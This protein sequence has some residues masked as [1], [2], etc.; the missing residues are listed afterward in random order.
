MIFGY[1][2]IIENMTDNRLKFERF[3]YALEQGQFSS[4]ITTHWHKPEQEASLV[5]IPA[6]LDAQLRLYLEANGFNGLYSHQAASFEAVRN[7]R[8]IIVSTG[9]SSGKTWCYNLPVLHTLFQVQQTRALYLFPTKALTEDQ[10]KK[11]ETI[12]AFLEENVSSEAG[13]QIKAGIYDGDTPAAKRKSIRNN[14]NIILTNPDMLHIGILPHHTVWSEFLAN[15]RYIVLDEVHT[16]R[17]VFGSHVANVLRRLKRVLAFYGAEPT[18]ILSS[19]TIQNPLELSEALVEEHFAA[20]TQDGSYQPER[21]YFFLNPPIVN[22]ELGLRRG[23]ID[24]SVEVEKEALDANIQSLVFARSRKTVE[25]TL[26]NLNERYLPIERPHM[27]GYRSG[28]LPSERR[29]IESG[30]REGSLSAVISTNA[31]ELGI[32][33]GGV[34]AVLLMGYPG[35]VASFLQQSGRAG[36][37][38]RP[39]LSV[40]VASSTPVDQYIIRHPDF[41]RGKNPEKAL[42]DPNN[43]L[44]LLNHLRCALFELP[45]VAGEGFG[46][47]SWQQI[48]PYLNALHEMAQATEKNEQFYWMSDQYPANEISLRNISGQSFA[49]RLSDGTRIGEIDYQTAPKIVHPDAIYMHNGNSFKVNKLDYETNQADLEPFDGTY[50]TEAKVNSEVELLETLNQSAGDAYVKE[51]DD[52]KVI[53]QV[54]GYKQV[55]WQTR[56]ILNHFELEMPSNELRTVGL[57]LKFSAQMVDALR[58][59]AVWNSDPNQYGQAWPA[60]RKLVL[61]RDQNRCQVCG[62]AGEANWLHVHHKIPFRTFASPQEANRPE[63]LVTLCPTCHRF[64]EQNVKIRSGLGGFAYLFANIAPLHLMCDQ[65]DIGY[66]ADPQSKYNQKQPMVVVYDQFPGGIGLSAELY[67]IADQVIADCRDVIRHC[68]CR[69]GCPSCVGPSGENGVGGKEAA[70]HITQNLLGNTK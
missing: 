5:A 61:A 7:G 16:Y 8:N 26:R 59:Q 31:M 53:E 24:Q 13:A 44:L 51:L 9:T 1:D 65:S 4:L 66:F 6:D 70:L 34:D 46:K 62:Q 38:Q 39:S 17:G 36:R 42:L 35:T 10:Y 3:I 52:L 30:L 60:I 48:E 67:N 47:L 23:L 11:L 29:A 18:F 50:F 58:A 69:D 2:L 45:F 20:I 56:D 57:A 21:Y 12:S 14:A 15:L 40:L 28:Y 54:T 33:M 22:E 64:A 19:A 68:G 37:R 27:Q 43:P 49:L 63:N 32:D 41:V 55:D 25:L